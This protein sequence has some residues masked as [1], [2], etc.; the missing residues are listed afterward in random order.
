MLLDNFSG[1]ESKEVSYRAIDLAA[2]TLVATVLSDYSEFS[3]YLESLLLET[4]S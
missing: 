3:K 2:C 1:S 4:Y